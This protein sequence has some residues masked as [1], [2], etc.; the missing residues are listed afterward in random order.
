[1]KKCTCGQ[2]EN[3]RE[4]STIAK[5]MDEMQTHNR[6]IGAPE[7]SLVRLRNDA[8]W[9]LCTRQGLDVETMAM[10]I[11]NYEFTIRE[12]RSKRKAKK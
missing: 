12:L 6:N 11:T 2:C 7:C 4:V 8:K 10:I 3:K 1:M 5:I 9:V